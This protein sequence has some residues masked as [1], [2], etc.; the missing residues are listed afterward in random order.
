M[1]KKRL[2]LLAAA[3]GCAGAA[4]AQ[5]LI[6]KRDASQIE[7]RVMEVAPD[8]VRYKRFSNPDGPT[9]VLP[10]VEIDY[11]RYVNGDVERF[12]RPADE[13]GAVSE[14]PASAVPEDLVLRRW[15]I[16]DYYE[17]GDVKGIVC[18]LTDE[19]THGLILSLDEIY[20]PW[21]LFRRP[22]RRAVGAV[23]PADGR[24]NMEQV[25][26]YIAE[27]GLSWD[28]FPAFK[29]C[30]DKGEGWYLP[31][32]DELLVI[33]HNYNGGTRLSYNRQ[34]RNLFNDALRG[35]GGERMDRMVYYFS[36]TERNE[37]SAMTTH[38]GIEPPYENDVPK[39]DKFLVRAVRR[40]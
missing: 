30:R 8:V 11:I 5:D 31:A 33:G 21:S 38:T 22:D 17:Q 28:D 34:A 13:G 2:L 12:G 36:S 14:M 19:G 4:V 15:K 23:D 20:L 1:M 7:A 25:A 24:V 18:L 10:V 32:I 6:V 29:W 40:F 26:R 9:Y 37:K 27:N 3:W 35:H 39:S 16:G